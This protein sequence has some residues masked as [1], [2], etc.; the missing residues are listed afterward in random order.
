MFLSSLLD[1][2]KELLDSN[3]L[4]DFTENT[5]AMG[6]L[7]QTLQDR[8]ASIL[9]SQQ[10]DKMALEVTPYFTGEKDIQLCTPVIP[11]DDVEALLAAFKDAGYDN[12]F[13]RE[14]IILQTAFPA[15]TSELLTIAELVLKSVSEE[16][17]QRLIKLNEARV[18]ST[19]DT[20]INYA[21]DPLTSGV[22]GGDRALVY[23]YGNHYHH[24]HNQRPTGPVYEIQ[25]FA[26]LGKVLATY[27]TF[28]HLYALHH[29]NYSDLIIWLV[30]RLTAPF[31]F[32][33]DTPPPVYPLFRHTQCRGEGAMELD[34]ALGRNASST[35]LMGLLK[36]SYRGTKVLSIDQMFEAA[37]ALYSYNRRYATY[38][39]EAAQEAAAPKKPFKS[40]LLQKCR[41]GMRDYTHRPAVQVKTKI[42]SQAIL[43]EYAHLVS[44]GMPAMAY[45]LHIA[46]PISEYDIPFYIGISSNTN[47]SILVPS[48]PKTMDMLYK[49]YGYKKRSALCPEHHE[50][51]ALTNP[52]AMHFPVAF[53]RELQSHCVYIYEERPAESTTG[54]L[55][56]TA[57]LVEDYTELG[58][59]YVGI[60]DFRK[61]VED[62]PVGEPS[63]N[64]LF[65]EFDITSVDTTTRYKLLKHF[66]HM[67]R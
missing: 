64:N 32:K 34:R 35:H 44:K 14:K 55:P 2:P 56:T 54:L 22:F 26:H 61:F 15:V 48:T 45:A 1:P 33:P 41:P 23:R 62:S 40:V 42:L 50:S 17:G 67:E 13:T 24:Y 16:S 52:M 10:L 25:E 6:P 65:H 39:A 37:L 38:A 66:Q 18:F 9:S 47:T 46:D 63:D 36:T 43:P 51:V 29:H 59:V 20:I 5:L 60:T 3:L 11:P 21:P 58:T 7:T 30:A 4:K 31:E 53:K 28:L 8:Y 49:C 57:A 19:R 12:L 27:A